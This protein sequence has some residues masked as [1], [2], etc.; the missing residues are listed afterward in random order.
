M[1]FSIDQSPGYQINRLAR[2]LS[3]YLQR[4]FSRAGF[5]ITAPQWA[6]LNRLWEEEGLH[7]SELAD[8]VVRD[9]HNMAR[10]IAA[11]E[12]RGLIRREPDAR[13]KRLLR[14]F[15]TR[16]GRE[17]QVKLV[18]LAKE[19]VASAFSSVSRQDVEALSRLYDRVLA[20]LAKESEE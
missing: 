4:K 12:K 16:Q 8:R 5:E 10:I 19:A 7:Q 11:M 20:N 6:V 15:L 2:D 3:M 1:A 18:P 17:L 14:V 13:D 9:R